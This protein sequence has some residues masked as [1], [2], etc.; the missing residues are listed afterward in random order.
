MSDPLIPANSI[1]SALTPG[2]FFCILSYQ[3]PEGLAPSLPLPIGNPCQVLSYTYPFVA[4]M[5]LS[6][7]GAFTHGPLVIDRRHF[8]LKPLP[9]AFVSSIIS[10]I[11]SPPVSSA[12]LTSFP[13]HP[14]SGQD[15]PTCPEVTIITPD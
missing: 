8:T 12:P 15:P 2:A 4:C 13:S 7:R 10:A 5:G 6:A 9:P 1:D 3:P 11:S 14:S